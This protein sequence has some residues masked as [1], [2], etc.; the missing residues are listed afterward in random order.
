MP[1][2][3]GSGSPVP[4]PMEEICSMTSMTT[5]ASTQVAMAK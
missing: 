2:R 3:P 5:E 1:D 4:P